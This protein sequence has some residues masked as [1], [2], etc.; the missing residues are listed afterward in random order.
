MTSRSTA[1]VK[2]AL[3][4]MVLFLEKYGVKIGLIHADRE[5]AFIALGT[6]SKFKFKFT[7]GPGT[8]EPMAER[9]IQ[10]VK[11]IF[12]TK[13]SSLPFHLPRFLYPRLLEHVVMLSNYRLRDGLTQT[14]DELLTGTK[15]SETELIRGS[16][17]RIALFKIPD[18]EV[19]IRKLDDLDDKAEYGV[20]VGMEHSNPRNLKVFL[21]MST[22]AIVTRQGGK[23]VENPGPVIEKMN[24]IA[25]EEEQAIL[26][27]PSTTTT[28]TEIDDDEIDQ[29]KVVNHASATELR[30]RTTDDAS[31][32]DEHVMHNAIDSDFHVDPGTM[33]R[34]SIKKALQVLPSSVVK[35]AVIQELVTNMREHE[36]WEYKLP[37][38]LKDKHILPSMLFIKVKTDPNGRYDKTKARLVPNGGLQRS[39][40]YGRS[41]SPTV[42]FSSLSVLFGLVKMLDAHVATVDVPAAYLN[43]PL[44]EEVYM[45][46]DKTVSSI[47]VE[48]DPTLTRYQHKDGSIVVQ[49]KKCIYGLKQSGFEWHVVLANFLTSDL[50]FKQSEADRCVFY[51]LTPSTIIVAVYVDDAFILYQNKEQYEAIK[52]KLDSRFGPMKFNEGSDHN[53]V[54]MHL[55]VMADKSIFAS[56]AEHTNNL[57]SA[58]QAWRI[59][60]DPKFKFKFYK[61]PS[62]PILHAWYRIGR[63]TLLTPSN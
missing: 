60:L 36:V 17:G 25:R 31:T 11:E 53:Y 38:D 9:A 54:G 10:T 26:K 43:A 18:E 23:E 24:E 21:P 8:H 19:R 14:P 56:Q 61:T 4:K 16:F 12:R 57:L 51:T 47:L 29:V 3:D 63:R 35:E 45:R 6:K 58:Y 28:T 13:K 41:S 49:L 39:D 30:P 15:I 40:E 27:K 34:L 1:D 7:G 46:L 52:A 55:Q 48:Q 32:R 62:S 42:D 22:K 33:D 2:S 20:I 50:S 37:G 5:G 44:K 59:G